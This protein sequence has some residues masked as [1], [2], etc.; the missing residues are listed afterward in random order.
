MVLN[1]ILR[2]NTQLTSG[3]LMLCGLLCQ[4]LQRP[5]S[6]SPELK[7]T[8]PLWCIKFGHSHKIFGSIFAPQDFFTVQFG[9]SLACFNL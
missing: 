9:N 2:K 8:H 7:N 4:I 1:F 3:Q 5:F 6:F